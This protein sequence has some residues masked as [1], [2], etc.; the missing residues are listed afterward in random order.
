ML[1]A[2][3]G[4]RIHFIV[5]GLVLGW[6]STAQVPGL[7]SPLRGGSTF[8][9]AM[10]GVSLALVLLRRRLPFGSLSRLLDEGV[11]S[12]A[13]AILLGRVGCLVQG[14]C[15]GRP[16]RVPWAV[17][18]PAGVTGQPASGPLPTQHPFVIYLGIWALCAAWLATRYASGR[19]GEARP[20]HRILAFV[21]FFSAGRLP[22][23]WF[24]FPPPRLLGGLN[25]AQWEALIL[26]ILGVFL[27][28]QMNQDRRQTG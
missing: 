1:A 15:L 7:L 20:G 24:R 23:E 6:L 4:G 5:E 9:G 11:W 13:I 25:V 3:I 19:E 22:L 26:T 28:R 10:A 18:F 12:L 21:T 14:C 8:F 2:G 17:A 16:S 27:L